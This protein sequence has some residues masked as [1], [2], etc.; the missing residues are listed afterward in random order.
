MNFLNELKAY[1]KDNI[2]VSVMKIIRGEYLTNPDFDPKLI[3]KASS[4][5]EGKP[6][7]SWCCW[8][9]CCLVWL[10][11]VVVVVVVVGNI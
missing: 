8:C 9:C 10:V 6:H 5:A 3:S 4:A 2:P 7:Q 1:D 11:F